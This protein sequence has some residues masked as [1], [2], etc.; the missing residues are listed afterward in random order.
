LQNSRFD[1][2][3]NFLPRA[4]SYLNENGPFCQ[5]AGENQ[6][7]DII[8]D[9]RQVR[10][11]GLLFQGRSLCRRRLHDADKISLLFEH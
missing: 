5:D 4:I 6:L 7:G 2:G 1:P 10:G 8:K 3:D 9:L 11:A